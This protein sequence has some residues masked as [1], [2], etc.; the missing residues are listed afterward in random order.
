ML[1]PSPFRTDMGLLIG[2]FYP[3][4]LHDKAHLWKT[5]VLSSLLA[6][7]VAAG[8]FGCLIFDV[9][10]EF[11]FLNFNIFFKTSHISAHEY[12]RKLVFT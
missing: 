6:V 11:L 4:K 10:N 2:Q 12:L 3:L 9:S 5:K 7:W 8:V 1:P